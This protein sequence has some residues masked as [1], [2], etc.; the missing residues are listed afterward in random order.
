MQKNSRPQKRMAEMRS[1]TENK[2]LHYATLPNV[3][4]DSTALLAITVTWVSRASNDHLPIF[5]V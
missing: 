4:S 1:V 5:P 3:T 2:I